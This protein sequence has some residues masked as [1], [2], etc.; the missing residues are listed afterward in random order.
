[1]IAVFQELKALKV[2]RGVV[3]QIKRGKRIREEHSWTSSF[4]SGFL[5]KTEQKLIKGLN[6]THSH[7][8]WHKQMASPRGENFP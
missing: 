7:E 2:W 1:M 3:I 4:V 8:S 5:E 6:H